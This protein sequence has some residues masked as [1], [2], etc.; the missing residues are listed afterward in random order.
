MHSDYEGVVAAMPCEFLLLNGSG[1]GGE[2]IL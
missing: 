2:C 1:G